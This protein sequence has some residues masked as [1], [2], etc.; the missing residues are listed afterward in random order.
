MKISQTLQRRKDRHKLAYALHFAQ[1]LSPAAR[2]Y[3]AVGDL[4]D[5]PSTSAVNAAL[6]PYGLTFAIIGDYKPRGQKAAATISAAETG[7][8]IARTE[9]RDTFDAYMKLRESFG[10]GRPAWTS[11]GGSGE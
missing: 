3:L 4:P 8:P 9:G 10:R 6:A 11:D 7:K 2:A 1:T 5:L